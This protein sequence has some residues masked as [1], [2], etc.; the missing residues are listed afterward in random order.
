VARE[1]WVEVWYLTVRERWKVL[2]SSLIGT[3]IGFLPGAGSDLAA[4]V[5]S[6]I[7]RMGGGNKDQIVLEGTSA[8]NAAI[9]GTWIPALALGIPGDTLTAIVLGM[10]L[11]L[12]IAPGPDLF[13]NHK[14]FVIQLYMAFIL[15]SV[16]VMPLCGYLSA[17]IVNKMMSIPMRLLLGS[18]IGLCMVGIYAINNN[19]FDLGLAV[20]IGVFGF[21]L[22]KG[23]FPLGQLILGMVLGPLLENYTMQSLI[24][25]H[26]DISSFFSRPVAIVLALANLALVATMLWMRHRAAQRAK[27]VI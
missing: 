14:D 16:I 18:V 12:G 19:P 4:W 23:G 13:I 11:T 10:F 3:F 2:R 21:F 6:N 24:K 26:A 20:T 7:S 15:S 8:N 17:L 22:R 27:V 25:S 1:F 9:G 5:S